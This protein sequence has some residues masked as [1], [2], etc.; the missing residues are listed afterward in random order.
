MKN[1]EKGSLPG[2]LLAK[3][4]YSMEI[5]LSKGKFADIDDADLDLVKSYKW[6][7]QKNRNTYYAIAFLGQH[8]GQ[9]KIFMHRLILDLIDPTIHTNHIDGNGLNNRR[10]NIRA[11]TDAENKRNVGNYSSNTSGYKGVCWHKRNRKWLAS[12]SFNGESIF[13][14]YFD[15]PILASKVYERAAKGLHG[16]F[17]Y[18]TPDVVEIIQQ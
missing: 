11:C 3:G 15:N 9:K 6:Y 17:Y 7:A 12:I 10:N 16:E 18:Q 5:K 14:G 8:K 2:V 4:L 13:L 1:G